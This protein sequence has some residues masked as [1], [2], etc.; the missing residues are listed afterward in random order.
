VLPIDGVVFAPGR[1]FA[2]FVM[3]GKRNTDEDSGEEGA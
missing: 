2:T 3:K 1:G